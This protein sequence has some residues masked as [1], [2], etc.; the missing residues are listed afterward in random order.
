MKARNLVKF[1]CSLAVVSCA[2][3]T[4]LSANAKAASVSLIYDE[5]N[6]TSQTACI[7][8]VVNDLSSISAYETTIGS[9]DAKIASYEV[10]SSLADM[11]HIFNITDGSFTPVGT[12][13]TATEPSLVDGTIYT[14][15]LTFESP[16]T[17]DT[18]ITW[19]DGVI[20]SL[21]NGEEIWFDDGDPISVTVKANPNAGGGETGGGS[22]EVDA[23]EG[24]DF[25]T[26]DDPHVKVFTADLAGTDHEGK[27]IKWV[28]TNTS[29]KL[30][31]PISATTDFT[32][33][34]DVKL[35]LKI[36]GDISE[37]ASAKL[38]IE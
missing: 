17:S 2:F 36:V 20:E 30:S 34:L 18:T 10:V 12:I 14:V 38:V 1:A 16:L 11:S 15:K 13:A 19:N 35:G 26:Y 8:F 7:S 9:A 33:G 31:E 37:I 29:G 6:S 5:A 23:G 3:M 28:L 32:G 4:A 27:T 25:I 22:T 21:A 24:Q